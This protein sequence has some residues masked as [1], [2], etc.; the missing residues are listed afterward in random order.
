[1]DASSKAS[2]WKPCRTSQSG[3][4]GGSGSRLS[5]VE[6]RWSQL[7]WVEIR[8]GFFWHENVP[9]SGQM[10][11]TSQGGDETWWFSLMKTTAKESGF[12][13]AKPSVGYGDLLVAGR[14]MIRKDLGLGTFLRV[15]SGKSW[16]LN[17]YVDPR[18]PCGNTMTTFGYPRLSV[19][20]KQPKITRNFTIWEEVSF[21]GWTCRLNE[22]SYNWY[23]IND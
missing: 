4:T 19:R 20:R 1:M 12:Q 13:A 15:G 7:E 10:T 3:G 14:N 8:D 17:I 22:Y 11:V 5:A 23:M 21:L 2:C 16:I 18:I 9:N 6:I